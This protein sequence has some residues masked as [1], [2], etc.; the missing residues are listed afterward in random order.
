MLDV[1]TVTADFVSSDKDK[2]V[3]DDATAVGPLLAYKN[4]YA[5]TNEGRIWVRDTRGTPATILDGSQITIDTGTGDADANGD[6]VSGDEI[7]TNIYTI[8]SFPGSPNPQVY[9]RQDHP[10]TGAHNTRIVEWSNTDQW[11]RG[12]MDAII[13]VKLGGSLIDSGLVDVFVRQTGDTFTHVASVDLSGGSRTPVATETAAD[14]INVTTGEHYLLYDAGS[15]GCFSVGDVIQNVSTA[16][17]N[18][19]D[20]YAEVVA[21][22]EFTVNTTGVLTLRGLRGTIANNDPIYVGT[23][24]EATV[25][26]TP[27]GTYTTASAVATQ[28]TVGLICTGGG[29]G[30]KR[31]LRGVDDGED[32]YVFQVDETVIGSSKDVYYLD[33]TSGETITDTGSGSVTHQA[34]TSTSITSDHTNITIAHVNGTVVASNFAGTFEPG[35]VVTWNAGGSSAILVAT[36][37]STEITLANVDSA[38]EP[39]AA[40]DFT[41]ASSGATAD[42]DSGLTDEYKESFAFPLQSGYEYA[43][44][45]EGGTVYSAAMTLAEIYAFLQY[46][47]RDGEATPMYT[48]NGTTITEIDGQ[49]YITPYSS[50]AVTKTAPFGTLAGGVFFGAQGVWIEGMV[51][52]DANN[53]RLTDDAGNPQQ[54]YTSVTV[55]ISN[56][57]VDDVI[58][59]FKE[60]G[61][62][63]LPDKAQ[64]SLVAN[65]QSASTLQ[66]SATFPNDTPPSGWAYAVDDDA[67][68]E[69]KYRY[70][71]WSTDTLTLAAEVSGTAEAGTSGQTLVDTGVFASGVERGDIIRRT[72]DDAWCYVIEVTD[73]DTVQTTVLSDG[74]DWAV[75]NPFEVNS[76]VVAYTTSDKLFIPYLEAIEDVGTEG[77]PGSEEQVIT[78]VSDRAVVIRVR[79]VEGVTPIQPFVTTSDITNTGMSVAVIRNEDEVYA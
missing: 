51:G 76:L 27:G 13:P 23:T 65:A 71:S 9:I 55:A 45:I 72:T 1:D 34:A 78:Y 56:T 59:V 73:N 66:A 20:W 12:S 24:Q 74:S 21:V 68:E 52:T 58:T 67:G 35:E 5:T 42:C 25:N 46:R 61:T 37:G 7:Y 77:S 39:D 22:T 43:A 26:G 16:N 18:P 54:P 47:C 15:T 17:L 4:D 69:H 41:G 44:F 19:P 33:F 8:A 57:R 14:T 29:S 63:G 38:D 53:I 60:D 75:G 40:D 2:D 36:N 6:S 31:I 3:E 70:T 10:Q 62:T 64:F 50:Y 48:S 32:A 28:L 79:N 11:D 49:F 30:A